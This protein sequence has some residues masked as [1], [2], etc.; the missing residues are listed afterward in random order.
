[1]AADSFNSTNV[2]AKKALVVSCY[3]WEW[4]EVLTIEGAGELRNLGYVVEYL[5]LS[6]FK[7]NPIKLILKSLLGR[8]ESRL[9]R[10]KVLRA[11]KIQVNHPAIRIGWTNFSLFLSLTLRLFSKTD[12]SAR[13][14]VVYPGLV[15]LTSDVN[16]GPKKNKE[17]VRKM[18]L[19]DRFFVK[20]LASQ[21]HLYASYDLVLIV[22]GRFPL[23]RAAAQYFKEKNLDV[24]LIEFGSSREKFE[25]YKKSPHS[26]ANRRE[27]FNEFIQKIE[28]SN[29]ELQRVSLAYFE[30]R[31]RFDKQANIRWTRKMKIAQ[32]P[33]LNPNKKICTFF[34]TS[35][36]EFA[37]VSDMTPFGEFANQ[38]EALESLIACLGPQ[39]EV[40][41]RRH[42]KATDDNF[43][44]E[45]NNW[46]KFQKYGNVHIIQ[47]QSDVDSYTL[48][49]QSDLVAH[50]SS[51][52]GPELIYSG[53]KFVI[54]LGP[55]PWQD[56]DP[57]RHLRSHEKLASYIRHR[58]DNFVTPDLNFLGY[59]MST[60]GRT[61]VNYSWQESKGRWKLRK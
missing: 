25:I 21:N 55:T 45:F 38:F 52:I 33:D 13:R 12:W 58:A 1:M 30:E 40:F 57:M 37:G 32:L 49:M 4:Q 60:F 17:L 22:N 54:T 56:L 5:D 11:S 24:Q 53:H 44:P 41:I 23:N 18:L 35:E 10:M 28:V 14:D 51:F 2:G 19:E 39:W 7:S 8:T 20:L 16:A 29:V 42:P 61:F 36:K 43:D 6:G 50:F 48:G 26:M 27:L 59:Y 9:A 47:P 46:T 34:P 15:E 3:N 31:R